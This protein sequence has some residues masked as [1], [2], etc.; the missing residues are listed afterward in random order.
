MLALSPH[1]EKDLRFNFDR[2]IFG[3]Y[4]ADIYGCQHE[5]AD[6]HGALAEL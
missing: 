6:A 1:A 5:D 3:K 2:L 4:F